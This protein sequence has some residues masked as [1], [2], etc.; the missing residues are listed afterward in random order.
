M[1]VLH[2]V[3]EPE[4]ALAEVVRVLKPGSRAI[5]GDMLPHDRELSAADGTRLAG[6]VG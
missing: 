1:L 3:P 6:I 5:I 4:K 2:H